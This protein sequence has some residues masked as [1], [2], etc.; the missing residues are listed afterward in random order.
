MGIFLCKRDSTFRHP[1]EERKPVDSMLLFLS[2][3]HALSGDNN[4]GE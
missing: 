1:A 3:A 2:L 4:F